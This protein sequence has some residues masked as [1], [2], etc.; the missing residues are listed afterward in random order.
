MSGLLAKLPR[1]TARQRDPGRWRCF[2]RHVSRHRLSSSA[3][4]GVGALAVAAAGIVAAAARGPDAVTTAQSRPHPHAT[5]STA[6]SPAPSLTTTAQ[7]A[8]TTSSPKHHVRA[9]EPPTVLPF[10]G[11]AP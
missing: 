10:T 8:D 1:G 3:V 7:H 11:P 4:L 2:S 6:P 5:V 9:H